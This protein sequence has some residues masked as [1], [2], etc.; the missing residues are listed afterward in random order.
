[1]LLHVKKDGMNMLSGVLAE[2]HHLVCTL[3]TS[4]IKNPVVKR[5]TNRHTESNCY[6]IFNS[7]TNNINYNLKHNELL[8]YIVTKPD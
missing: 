6:I 4:W 3:K 8:V 5:K 1:M 2:V 7:H